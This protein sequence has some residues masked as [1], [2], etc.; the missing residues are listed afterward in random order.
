MT[1]RGEEER[2]GR[3][4]REGGEG[5]EREEGVKGGIWAIWQQEVAGCTTGRFQNLKTRCTQC[6]KISLS[7]S[8]RTQTS[9]T[10]LADIYIHTRICTPTYI[11]YIYA[12]TYLRVRARKPPPAA[13][14]LHTCPRTNDA[15]PLTHT[16][17]RVQ[18]YIYNSRRRIPAVPWSNT[19]HITLPN[20]LYIFNPPTREEGV[21]RRAGVPPDPAVKLLGFP[22]HV[23]QQRVPAPA[24]AVPWTEGKGVGR[25]GEE[26]GRGA[27]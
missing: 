26:Q 24:P 10:T 11:H 8:H 27:T 16:R 21:L 3:G 17:T 2:G 22:Q 20:P 7:P 4:E 5:E 14:A 13:H 23:L 12:Q 15:Q 25:G 6:T 9:T 18:H 19:P 1:R